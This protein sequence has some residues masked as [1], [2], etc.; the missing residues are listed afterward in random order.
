VAVTIKDLARICG[1]SVGT[2]DRALRNRSEIHPRTRE[3]ILTAAREHGY[4]P[5][6][7]ARNLKARRTWEIG[8]VVHDLE[9]EFFAELVNAVQEVAW[10]QGYFLQIAVS[11]RDPARER[12]G[13]EH[14]AGRNVDGILLFPTSADNG[15]DDFL[16]R[17]DRP[18]VTIANRVSPAWPFVGLK[19][20]T[21]VREATRDVIRRGYR[22]LVFVGPF[23]AFAERIN[24]YEIEERYA[25]LLEA[26]REAPGI[27]SCLLS[28]ADY[29]EKV[30]AL[31][32]RETRTAV[33]CASDI[34][35]LEILRDL[36]TREVAVP[37]DVGLMGF[38]AIDA[39]RYVVPSLS[40]VAYPVQEMGE[41]AFSL[42]TQPPTG[43]D[44]AFI[45]LEPR[46]VWG[47]SL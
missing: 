18:I 33:L 13:L 29:V 35:A 3:R 32:F 43:K 39:L 10:R 17:L 41:T 36:R 26:V 40:T 22:R 5:N 45:E 7:V 15:F 8:L 20:R 24:L 30:R 27:E 12:A 21:I 44:V 34:F 28:G 37:R 25:G 47:E 46:I 23:D 2:V 11:R 19:D 31:D 42:L 6:I 4:K 1:V 16:R 9:N 38:D 14:M